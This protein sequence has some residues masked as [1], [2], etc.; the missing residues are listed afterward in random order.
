MTCWA[1][2]LLQSYTNTGG[3]QIQM[4]RGLYRVMFFCFAKILRFP[5]EN[6]VL[7]LWETLLKEFPFYLS[8]FYSNYS[9]LEPGRA[10]DEETSNCFLFTI[11]LC[12]PKLS[13]QQGFVC[14]TFTSPP[15]PKHCNQTIVPL[16]TAQSPSTPSRFPLSVQMNTCL[17]ST[18][19]NKL[20]II[21]CLAC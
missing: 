3:L 20:M 16:V 19:R 8:L 6:I 5:G 7:A 13:A 21:S 17:K 2:A 1:I 4:Y 18:P 11:S 9:Y 14:C 12:V 15:L 10:N